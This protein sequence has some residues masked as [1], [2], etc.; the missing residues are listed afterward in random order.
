[1]DYI[2]NKQ[3]IIEPYYEGKEYIFFGFILNKQL[4]PL[5]ITQKEKV[6]SEKDPLF[7]CD[8]IHYYPNDLTY[9]TKLKFFKFVI[10]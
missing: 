6:Q 8:T 9:E 5:L 3:Y 10:I 7:L 1:M 2:Q 4:Y